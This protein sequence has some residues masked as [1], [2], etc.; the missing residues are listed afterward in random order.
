M[1]TRG[2]VYFLFI[3]HRSSSISM[4]SL[5]YPPF[6]LTDKST[7]AQRWRKYLDRFQNY[8][9]AMNIE[10]PKRKKALLLHFSG[11]G[12]HDI[13]DTLTIAEPAPPAEGA[14]TDVYTPTVEAL[15]RYFVPKTNNTYNLYQFRQMKQNTEESL[16]MYHTRL[17]S[18]AQLC[19]FQNINEE[20]KSQIIVGCRSNKLRRM[21][22][23]DSD[24]TLDR[25]LDRGR[26][27]ETSNRQAQAMEGEASAN[28]ITTRR[29][30]SRNQGQQRNPPS[31]PFNPNQNQQGYQNQGQTPQK[32]CGLC[33]YGYP[34][35]G[36]R[37][38]CPANGKTCKTCNKLNHFAK[39][40][41]SGTAPN[42]NMPKQKPAKARQTKAN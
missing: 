28:K 29:K 25:L 6:D 11:P 9:I 13:H 15:N 19:N 40:C 12:V 18:Q 37:S 1:V 8:L 24:I 4:D 22:L 20:L 41:R 34:H 17:S 5:S 10:S 32:T 3:P 31:K 26:A 39:V 16:D 33:G 30:P 7:T 27:L 23:E 42:P 2:T 21:A 38:K 36:G 14:E 35:Q